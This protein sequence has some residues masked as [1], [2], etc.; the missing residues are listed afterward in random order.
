MRR[1]RHDFYGNQK[2]RKSE[3]N[4]DQETKKIKK[5]SVHDVNE[6]DH[7]LTRKHE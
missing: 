3:L 5:K 6:F 4:L 1:I 7:F 2:I